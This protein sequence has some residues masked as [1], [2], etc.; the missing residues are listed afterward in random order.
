MAAKSQSAKTAVEKALEASSAAAT[1]SEKAD[2][3]LEKSEAKAKPAA[4]EK[5]D[6]KPEKPKAKAKPVEADPLIKTLSEL[7]QLSL[8]DRQAFRLAGGT[9][10][11]DP[12]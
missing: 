6:P 10:T 9:V 5:S 8:A 2:P 4:P 1:T 3:K 7:E 11:N 12:A